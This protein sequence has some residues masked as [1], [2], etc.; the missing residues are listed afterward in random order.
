MSWQDIVKVSITEGLF[1]QTKEKMRDIKA[2]LSGLENSYT[3]TAL[4][5]IVHIYEQA[6]KAHRENNKK[7]LGFHLRTMTI[8][9][10][11]ISN[12]FDAQDIVKGSDNE[13]N[14]S[15]DSFR[16]Y[17]KA[18]KEN[19]TSAKDDISTRSPELQKGARTYPQ[20]IE[21]VG[22]LFS[23]GKIDMKRYTELRKELQE[24]F[25]VGE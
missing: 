14:I 2:Q 18:S 24:I 5:E 4:D 22:K 13:R 12:Y 20:G 23:K 17:G 1:N 16:E 10:K 19:P 3:K 21:K 25:G 7:L 8:I 15:A 9:G 6:K 11:D